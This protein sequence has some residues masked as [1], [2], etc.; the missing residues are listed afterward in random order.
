MPLELLV[1]WS[2]PTESVAVDS[3]AA[4][5]AVPWVA[6][7]RK[8]PIQ[9]P[10]GLGAFEFVV[11]ATLRAAQLM[12]GCRPRIEGA[13]KATMLA[14]WEVAEGLVTPVWNNRVTLTVDAAEG[15]ATRNGSTKSLP[16]GQVL[17]PVT[18]AG[19]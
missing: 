4:A 2:E 6:P 15:E 7:L 3:T 19:H 9:R 17:E 12:R 18:T 5:E 10:T 1:P 13:H 11:V 16:T 8:S 14:Q